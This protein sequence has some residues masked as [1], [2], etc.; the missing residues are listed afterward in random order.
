MAG[1]VHDATDEFMHSK[2]SRGHDAHLNGR[3]AIASAC[4]SRAAARASEL[5]A[6]A[7]ADSLVSG[8]VALRKTQAPELVAF[9]LARGWLPRLSAVFG[10]VCLMQV[11]Q[12]SCSLLD[13]GTS[14]PFDAGEEQQLEVRVLRAIDALVEWKHVVPPGCMEERA[15]ANESQSFLTARRW[16]PRSEHGFAASERSGRAAHSHAAAAVRV[17]VNRRGGSA[18]AER[19]PHSRRTRS[20]RSVFA[21]PA[22]DANRAPAGRGA[23]HRRIGGRAVAGLESAARDKIRTRHAVLR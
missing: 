19:C 23:R 8:S 2:I 17:I 3:F 6:A 11:G 5:F 22:P 14:F 15:F 16:D 7:A 18:A 10:Y 4:F 12:D 21:P 1:V 20:L 13:M 9:L